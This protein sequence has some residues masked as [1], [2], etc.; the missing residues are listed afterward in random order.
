MMV[1]LAMLDIFVGANAFLIC[2]SLR[3][4]SLHFIR[5]RRREVIYS[6]SML[7]IWFLPYMG[8]NFLF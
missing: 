1:P 8:V 5:H 6:H 2:R 4:K 7:R 3:N